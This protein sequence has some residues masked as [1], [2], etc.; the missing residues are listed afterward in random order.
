MDFRLF[1]ALE[2]E[3]GGA[4]LTLGGFN[5][6]AVLGCLL[7][8][9]NRICTTP[10]LLHAL[11]PDD[12]PPTAKK[13]VHNA[14]SGLRRL[15]GTCGDGTDMITTRPPGY[16]LRVDP[17]WVDLFRFRDLVG[18]GRADLSIGE[19]EPA[20][21]KLRQALTMSQE[22]VLV[23]LVAEGV[24]W[25]VL[26]ALEQERTDVLEDCIEAELASGRH[27]QVLHEVTQIIQASPTRER[28]CGQAMLALYRSG[29]QT[30]ALSVYQRTRSCLVRDHGV[31]PG[32]E[33]QQLQLS[34][35]THDPSLEVHTASSAACLRLAT[36]R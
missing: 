31:E 15:L 7:I 2:V 33:L 8:N 20:A 34:I 4:L 18:E 25:P 29:R 26:V 3:A 11:W 10:Q 9:P 24:N 30:E 6:R 16:L 14:V 12:P 36:S 13:M 32:R 28:V 5:Q 23:D 27:R 1:G 35:L 19:W 22:P 17:D 21:H